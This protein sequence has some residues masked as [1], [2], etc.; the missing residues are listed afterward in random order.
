MHATFKTCRE[1]SE[2]VRDANNLARARAVVTGAG[3]LTPL[4]VTAEETWGSL[5][6]GGYIRDHSPIPLPEGKSGRPRV[7]ELAIA[8]AAQAVG[9]SGWSREQLLDDA[10]AL[11]VGTSKGPIESWMT[12]PPQSA[13]GSDATFGLAETASDVAMAVGLGM[14]PRV[15]VS[16]ACAT[17]LHAIIRGTMLIEAGVAKRVLVVAA[18]SSLGP[19][20]V[21]SFKRLGVLA[22]DGCRPFDQART[23]FLMSEGAAA[24]CLEPPA[25]EANRDGAAGRVG[26]ESYALGADATHLT[27]GD[28]EGHTLRHLIGTVMAGRPVDFVHAHGTGTEINDATELSAIDATLNGIG[29]G[30]CP[31]YS[32][33]AALGHS[34]GAAGLTSVVLSSMVHRTGIVPSNVRTK[35]PMATR[36]AL[37]IHEAVQRPVNRSLAIAAGFGGAAAVISLTS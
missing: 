13:G 22:R 10:T 35:N 9:E 19:L 4:G 16:A 5:L 17:G 3:L 33:K 20:F 32:H 34:L 6:A 8:V 24:V 23:G 18:E 7:N 21:G 2:R 26:I 25:S 30:G 28:R 36:N 31:V 15:T 29:Q 11:V 14:G 37:V 27:G 12:P 1:R